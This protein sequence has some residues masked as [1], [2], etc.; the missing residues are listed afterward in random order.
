MKSRSFCQLSSNMP[1]DVD[2]NQVIVAVHNDSVTVIPLVD[3]EFRMM[4]LT[5]KE[6][7]AH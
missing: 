6:S 5:R 4:M 3:L 1:L 7:A 2:V